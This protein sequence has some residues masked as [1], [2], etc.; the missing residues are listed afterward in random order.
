VG[1]IQIAEPANVEWDEHRP[2]HDISSGGMAASIA[3]F[4]GMH[5]RPRTESG[6]RYGTERVTGPGTTNRGTARR[7]G[8]CHWCS[9][10]RQINRTAPIAGGQ[11]WCTVGWPHASQCVRARRTMRGGVVAGGGSVGRENGSTAMTPQLYPSRCTSRNMKCAARAS[12]S[13]PPL[14][15]AVV[16]RDPRYE[17]GS[18]ASAMAGLIT[19]CR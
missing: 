13:R 15:P 19:S 9:Q 2:E 5:A 17:F 6:E 16:D 18:L 8:M 14:Y 1:R 10:V 4:V 12:P 11:A 7:S 3:V